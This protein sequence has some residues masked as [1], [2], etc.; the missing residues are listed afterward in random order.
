MYKTP[1]VPNLSMN[2]G[3]QTRNMNNSWMACHIL[4][5]LRLRFS[6]FTHRSTSSRGWSVPSH[7]I[8]FHFMT[9]IQASEDDVIPLSRPI[10]TASGEMTDCIS[11]SKG[12]LIRLPIAAVNKSKLLWGEDA[13]E[14]KPQRWLDGRMLEGGQ[15]VLAAEIQG[16]RHLLTFGGHGPRTCPGRQFAVI[17]FKVRQTI[18]LVLIAC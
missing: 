8:P 15:G 1:F 17:Q 3:Q 10:Q 4:M 7:L 11:V 14:F 5:P 9:F 13:L 18:P 6:G 16:Y 2:L 12:T